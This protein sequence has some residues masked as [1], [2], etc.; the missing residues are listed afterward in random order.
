MAYE[1]TA[2][3]VLWR[4]KFGRARAGGSAIARIM[5]ERCQVDRRSLIAY[6]PTATGRVR[7]R[8][9]D[10][11]ALIAHAYAR[12]FEL[13][14]IPLLTRTGQLQQRTATRQERL[15]QLRTAFVV[16]E[17]QRVRGRRVVVI[18]DV[19]TTGG[20]LD[21]AASVLRLAGAHRVEG[22]VYAQA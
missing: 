5:Q 19:V 2:K 15:T 20:T 1:E 13:E 11:A 6:I 12:A 3:Q 14:V 16:T 10:Q 17:P 8:G 22:L 9:Y 18:D 21:A 4:L 7:R